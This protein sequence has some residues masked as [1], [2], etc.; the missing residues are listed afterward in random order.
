MNYKLGLF[1]FITGAGRAFALIL[2]T[3]ITDHKGVKEEAESAANEVP[4]RESEDFAYRGQR[5]VVAY[6]GFSVSYLSRY[7][8]IARD[9]LSL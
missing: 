4:H 9:S 1:R 6:P 3:G 7:S 8:L 5:V 2:I